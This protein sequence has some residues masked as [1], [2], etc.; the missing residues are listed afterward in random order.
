MLRTNKMTGNFIRTI[1]FLSLTAALN[2]Q[3]KPP[4]GII[5]IYGQRKISEEKIRTALQI[6]EGDFATESESEIE[7]RI[8]AIPGIEQVSASLICCDDIKHSRM[9]Y[10]GIREK[11]TKP[12]SYRPA[13]KGKIRLPA[14]IVKTENDLF[15]AIKQAVLKNDAV[16]DQSQG[17]SLA[18]NPE[19]RRFQLQFI[20]YANQ[21]L[22]LLRRVIRESSNAE[23]RALAAEI[24]AYYKDKRAVIS[25]LVYAAEDSDSGVRNNAIRAL[26]VIAQYATDSKRADLK[27]P[28]AP[29]VEM[30]NSAV[31]TDRDK[32]AWLLSRL[33]AARDPKMYAALRRN[34]FDSLAEI[35]RWKNPGHALLGLLIL[36]HLADFKDNEI[37]EMWQKGEGEVIIEKVKNLNY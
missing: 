13:P 14:A 27:I 31:W 17:H 1:I 21:N 8:A 28:Y 32:S 35:A 34:A 24:I 12:F 30:L 22:P 26:G 2:A 6:K 29:F 11:G 36:G 18:N 37:F 19:A 5:D 3:T 33:T 25:D 23:H 4:V 16:E 15:E 20:E 9:L 10:I 7:K